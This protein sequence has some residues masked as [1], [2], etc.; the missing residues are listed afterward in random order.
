MNWVIAYLVGMAVAGVVVGYTMAK[1]FAEGPG[2]IFAV[3]FWPIG[4]P[5]VTG[6]LLRGSADQRKEQREIA[7]LERRRLLDCPI[8][9]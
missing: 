9:D 3:L 4:L 7:D 2:P 6:M 8:P 5:V 1:D